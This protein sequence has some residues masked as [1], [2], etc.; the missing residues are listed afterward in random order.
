MVFGTDYFIRGSNFME[1]TRELIDSIGLTPYERAMLY[2]EN[3]R[4]ILQLDI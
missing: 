1:R 4:R 3:A 2:S